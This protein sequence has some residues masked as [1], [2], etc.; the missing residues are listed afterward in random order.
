MAYWLY[1][2]IRDKRRANNNPEPWADSQ[3]LQLDTV[4]HKNTR[5]TSM[6]ADLSRGSGEQLRTEVDEAAAKQEKKEMR[7]YR[8]RLIAGLFM[9]ATVQALNTTLIAGALPFIASDFSEY[10]SF[11]IQ[12][13]ADEN[14]KWCTLCRMPRQSGA[15]RC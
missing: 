9:P 12:L 2:K 7:V 14:T 6:E 5:N 1:K 11:R 10:P 8:W 13:P 3:T 4:R 15:M